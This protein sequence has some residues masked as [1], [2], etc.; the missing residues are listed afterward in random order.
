[1]RTAASLSP[2]RSLEVL[3]LLRAW[4]KKEAMVEETYMCPSCDSSVRVGGICPKCGPPKRKSRKKVRT[5]KVSRREPKSWEQDESMDG[6][7]LPGEGFDYDEFVA[8]E[9]G[10]KPHRRIGIKWYWWLTG[11][12]V[13][14]VFAWMAFGGM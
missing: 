8:R 10:T 14:V 3:H 11:A 6:L 4:R 1:M 9:F 13:L 7:D 12:V 5:I 2:A